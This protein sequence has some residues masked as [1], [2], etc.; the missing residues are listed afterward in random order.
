MGSGSKKT[1]SYSSVAA[2][3]PAIEESSGGDVLLAGEVGQSIEA[4]EAGAYGHDPEGYEKFA[5]AGV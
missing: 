2:I 1:P 3:S 4:I 5:K